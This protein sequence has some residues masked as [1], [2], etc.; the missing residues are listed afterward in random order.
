MTQTYQQSFVNQVRSMWK[1]SCDSDAI[2]TFSVDDEPD[3]SDDE[4]AAAA[5]GRSAKSVYES[6]GELRRFEDSIIF[7]WLILILVAPDESIGSAAP[8]AAPKYSHP[9]DES[10]LK[11][12]SLAAGVEHCNKSHH[13]HS[14][15]HTN[16]MHKSGE[17]DAKKELLT[18]SDA[19]FTFS[20]NGEPRLGGRVLLKRMRYYALPWCFRQLGPKSSRTASEL[21]GC[22]INRLKLSLKCWRGAIEFKHIHLR[23][24]K[25]ILYLHLV[26]K[27]IGYIKNL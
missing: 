11:Q 17:V 25:L 1:L 27:F 12:Q 7:I 16:R 23:I 8:T 21:L 6:T 13:K 14:E 19:I 4:H 22:K 2:F 3:E 5:H 18:D 9:A 24:K 15:L 10:E 26:K 20:G